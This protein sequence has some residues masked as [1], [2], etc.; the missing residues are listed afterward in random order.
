MSQRC[1]KNREKVRGEGNVGM[2]VFR[3]VIQG[4]DNVQMKSVRSRVRDKPR[5]DIQAS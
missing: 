5:K 2:R 4:S 1:G 3:Q